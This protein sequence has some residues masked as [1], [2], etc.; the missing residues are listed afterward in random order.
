MLIVI[1]IKWMDLFL[2]SKTNTRFEY[3]PLIVA[4]IGVMGIIAV[5]KFFAGV[6]DAEDENN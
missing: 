4:G 3:A 2:V 5:F 1:I 6:E